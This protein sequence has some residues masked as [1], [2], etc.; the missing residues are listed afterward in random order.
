M[1]RVYFISS[2]RKVLWSGGVRPEQKSAAGLW[3]KASLGRPQKPQLQTPDIQVKRP[4]Y[5]QTQTFRRWMVYMCGDLQYNTSNKDYGT[6][7][8]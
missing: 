7:E 8:L 6:F 2:Q 4:L 1:L 3:N 5:I